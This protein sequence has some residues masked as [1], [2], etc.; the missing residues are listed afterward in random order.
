MDEIYSHHCFKMMFNIFYPLNAG[1]L[2]TKQNKTGSAND[3]PGNKRGRRS[4]TASPVCS[5]SQPLNSRRAVISTPEHQR[6][7]VLSPGGR[8][9]LTLTPENSSTQRE[10]KKLEDY[11]TR[12]NPVKED[13]PRLR[14][15]RKVIFNIKDCF[16]ERK[17]P[18]IHQNEVKPEQS[19]NTKLQKCLPES[20]IPI[21]LQASTTSEINGASKDK[22]E[23]QSNNP[24][25]P[26]DVDDRFQT[27]E[28]IDSRS[29]KSDQNSKPCKQTKELTINNVATP[30]VADIDSSDSDD[31]DY[32]P[33]RKKLRSEVSQD[34]LWEGI[35]L[36]VSFK[37]LAPIPKVSSLKT[38][39]DSL[40]IFPV[41]VNNSKEEITSTET[42]RDEDFRHLTKS[43]TDTIPTDTDNTFSGQTSES[44]IK[45][46]RSMRLKEKEKNTG[47]LTKSK[48]TNIFSGE[49]SPVVRVTRMNNSHKAEDSCSKIQATDVKDSYSKSDMNET[50]L[51]ANKEEVENDET[52]A[53]NDNPGETLLSLTL[54]QILS[55]DNKGNDLQEVMANGK[56]DDNEADE[57]T[58]IEA[59]NKKSPNCVTSSFSR[60]IND[61]FEEISGS[62]GL[63][64]EH[65]N[66]DAT[67]SDCV[68]ENSPRMVTR[69][70]RRLS[71]NYLQMLL[72]FIL[73]FIIR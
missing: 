70:S 21:I 48:G 14:S 50:I 37:R 26:N 22:K 6:S 62:D 72:P 18:K 4:K 27:E 5:S 54:S 66:E 51:Y 39:D 31:D 15:T 59:G 73:F 29:D 19:V 24:D 44:G 11:W 52:K 8:R 35:P 3:S 2:K 56:I 64:E 17:S 1:N 42:G 55:D 30:D 13:S 36:T 69:R 45:R 65:S 20:P 57:T 46:K 7:S 34:E 68:E 23:R 32:V 38:T 71:G 58:D 40:K 49:H 33:P 43:M 61:I 47:T 53:G 25:V 10:L 16:G 28:D 9:T 41:N 12:N 63:S 67:R 60:T